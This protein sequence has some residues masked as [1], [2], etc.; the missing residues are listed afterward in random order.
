MKSIS[1]PLAVVAAAALSLSGCAA[2]EGS[3]ASTADTSTAQGSGLTGTL[4]GKGASSQS[5]A[6]QT[7]IAGFQTPGLTINYSPDGSGAGREGFAQGAVAFAGTDRALNDDEMTAGSF[8]SCAADSSAL[9]LPVYIS[10]IAIIF[11]VDGVDELSLTPDAVAQIF[12]G[13]ITTWNDPAIAA[14]NEGVALPEATITEVHRSVDSG[15]TEN[16]TDYLHQV[17]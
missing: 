16:F 14:T 8:G 2:N 17:A 13:E 11:N 9:N 1:T 4:A 7:W 5:V 6:Q 15:T 10:P 3:M 12:A